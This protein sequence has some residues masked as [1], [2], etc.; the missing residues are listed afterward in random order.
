[1]AKRNRNYNK[2][3]IL[4][5][6]KTGEYTQSE[7]ARK[8]KVSAA[9]VSALVKG[10]PQNLAE[11][12]D[13][14]IT[15]KQEL[16]AYNEKERDLF[17][18]IVNDK[19]AHIHFFTNAAVLNVQQAMA[20]QCEDQQDFKLRAETISKGREVVLGKEPAAA[21]QI[22]NTQTISAVKASDDDLLNIATGSR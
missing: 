1:M 15:I 6:W 5:E 10:V 8:H 2:E 4:A 21:I 13:N 14:Q 17:T 22:N 11:L 18:K 16:A 3:A 12:I 9:T 20:A 19:T 7:I